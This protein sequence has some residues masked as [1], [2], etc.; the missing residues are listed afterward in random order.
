MLNCHLLSLSSLTIDTVIKNVQLSYT[1]EKSPLQVEE[2]IGIQ[3]ERSCYL[4]C[5]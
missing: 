4:K 1:T 3:L 2:G 5:Y